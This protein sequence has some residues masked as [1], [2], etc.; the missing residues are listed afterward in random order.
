MPGVDGVELLRQVKERWPAIQRIMLTGYADQQAIE[1]A[2]NRSEVYRFIAKPWD[3]GHLQMTVVSAY[4]QWQLVEENARLFHL[5]QAQNQTLEAKVAER[6]RM[7]SLAK[8]EWELSFDAIADP[9]AVVGADRRVKRANLAYARA[10]GVEVQAVPGQP[11]HQV[12]FGRDTPCEGCRLGEVLRTGEQRSF[13]CAADEDR[14]YRVD[15]YRLPP[16]PEGGDRA[17]VYYRDVTEEERI[18]RQLVQTEK[19]AAVGQLAG[20]VAHEINNPLA[21]ILAFAQMMRTDPGRSADDDEQLALIEDSARRCTRIVESLLH[22]SR[23][24]SSETEGTIDVAR[25][26]HDVQVLSGPVVKGLP[27]DL[28]FTVA[29]DLP[30]VAGDTNRLEQV[31]MNLVTNAAQALEGRGRIRV[32]AAPTGDGLRITVEDSGPGVPDDLVARIFDPF[33]TTK[34]EGEGTG[35][36]LAISYRIVEAHGGTLA[37]GTSEALGGA[38][39]TIDLPAG[40]TP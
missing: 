19:M 12:L 6:T 31:V 16:D 18:T 4:E 2:I 8:A 26:F 15:A 27:V 7:L 17:V 38:S 34:P 1:D 25:L 39:F 3:D 5:T 40:G 37:V 33:F 24:S 11:C 30:E 28:E 32:L 9:L 14:H 29:D 23:T 22:F 10:A 20:G 21:G 36:G 13:H 35:L